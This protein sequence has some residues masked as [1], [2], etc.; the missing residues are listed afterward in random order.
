M[1]AKWEGT[2]HVFSK[3]NTSRQEKALVVFLQLLSFHKEDPALLEEM[4]SWQ[5]GGGRG[6]RLT[7]W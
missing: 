2:H 1:G 7:W 3:S 6:E 4:H 5:G